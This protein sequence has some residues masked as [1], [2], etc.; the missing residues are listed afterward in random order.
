MVKDLMF[1]EETYYVGRNGTG[2]QKGIGFTRN[3]KSLQIE[4]INS[5]GN[6]ANCIMNIPVA[7]IPQMIER[8]QEVL[9]IGNE[10]KITRINQI[11]NEWGETTSTELNLN[12]SP[13]LLSTGQ[14]NYNISHLIENYYID[15]V[16][17][18]VY[19]GDFENEDSSYCLP[20]EQLPTEILDEVYNIMEKYY[21]DCFA[22]TLD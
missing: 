17:I 4:P 11:I 8:L 22:G 19:V 16:G 14:G 7:D 3:V 20:Y 18:N 13:C 21:S 5:K 12:A 9:K 1:S 15:G 10:A 6:L 2:R